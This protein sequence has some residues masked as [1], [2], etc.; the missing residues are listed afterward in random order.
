MYTGFKEKLNELKHTLE[1]K[2]NMNTE[3]VLPVEEVVAPADPVVETPVEAPVETAA[4]EA[5]EDMTVKAIKVREK[6]MKFFNEE[7]KHDGFATIVTNADGIPGPLLFASETNHQALVL[8]LAVGQCNVIND[9]NR[10][11]A[12]QKAAEAAAAQ[13]P[14]EPTAEQSSEVPVA[15][16]AQA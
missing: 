10:K 7:V 16:E 3:S 9:F 1:R 14:Q 8:M 6:I 13:A 4:E 2:L 12:E 15:T 5:P 11:I